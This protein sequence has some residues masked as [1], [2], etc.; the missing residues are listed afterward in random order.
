MRAVGQRKVGEYV[1]QGKDDQPEDS[2]LAALFAGQRAELVRFLAARCGDADE[3]QDLVQDLWLKARTLPAGPIGNGRAYLFRMANNLVLDRRRSRQR[4]M[5]RDHQ[6]LDEAGGGLALPED[7]PDPGPRADD[8]LVRREEAEVLRRAIDALPPGA[9]RALR[10]HRFEGL[11]QGEVAERM[12]ISR[13]GVEKHLAVAM[14]HLRNALSD[15]GYFTAA[16]SGDQGHPRG[17]DPQA[18]SQR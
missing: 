10:L 17:A 12:G 5:R 7:R 2:G 1:G 18:E 8:E 9:Q 11:P 16:T 15:C 4:A 3:A 13:S 6:W 14:R